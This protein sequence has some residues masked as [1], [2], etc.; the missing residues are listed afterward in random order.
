MTH[1]AEDIVTRVAEMGPF[2]YWDRGEG[3]GLVCVCA[4]CNYETGDSGD[5]LEA[6]HAVKNHDPDCVWR[7]ACE[8]VSEA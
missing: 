7:M 5:Q 4:S 8:H 1:K 3:D 6:I 2:W